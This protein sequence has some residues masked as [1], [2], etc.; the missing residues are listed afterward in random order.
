MNPPQPRLLETDEARMQ[1]YYFQGIDRVAVHQQELRKAWFFGYAAGLFGVVSS[2]TNTC[3]VGVGGLGEFLSKTWLVAQRDSVADLYFRPPSNTSR[4]A[5]GVQKVAA[6]SLTV[7]IN[8]A[9]DD[10]IPPGPAILGIRAARRSLA[11]NP[12]DA[13]SYFRLA[14]LYQALATQTRERHWNMYGRADSQRLLSN[15]GLRGE[16]LVSSVVLDE[17]G[18]LRRVQY[19][20]ALKQ[21]EILAPDE[22]DIQLALADQYEQMGFTDLAVKHKSQALDLF[23]QAG[24][25]SEENREEF[26]N[27]MESF[28]DQVDRQQRRVDLAENEYQ[29]QALHVQRPLDKAMLAQRYGLMGKAV[30]IVLEL[31][32]GDLNPQVVQLQLELL[33]QTGRIDELVAR[34]CGPDRRWKPELAR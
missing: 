25:P 20:A 10:D 16:P 31:G 18:V 23:R 1:L 13:A 15:F 3:P 5:E 26:E 2:A 11:N 22:I 27:K 24:P 19:I 6:A 33:L 4:A 8:R 29:K 14:T 28:Q 32:A 12:E 7:F 34:Y 9:A 21:A 30:D 17:L